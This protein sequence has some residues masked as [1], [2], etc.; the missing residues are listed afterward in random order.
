MMPFCVHKRVDQG[1]E[2][3]Y[4]FNFHI[5]PLNDITMNNRWDD[6]IISLSISIFLLVWKRKSSQS[7][8]G[9][10]FLFGASCTLQNYLSLIRVRLVFRSHFV[11]KCNA[12]CQLPFPWTKIEPNLTL[13]NEKKLFR[14]ELSPNRNLLS[15]YFLKI[16]CTYSTVQWKTKYH[17][18]HYPRYNETSLTIFP[19]QLDHIFKSY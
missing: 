17:L 12:V 19:I 14:E 9:K 2:S 11:C 15:T 6:A 7:E 1:Y 4:Q 10:S 13:V 16:Y 8:S 5:D 3:F 18:T